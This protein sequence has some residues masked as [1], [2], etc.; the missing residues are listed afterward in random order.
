MDTREKTDKYISILRESFHTVFVNTEQSEDFWKKIESF[1]QLDKENYGKLLDCLYLLEDTQLAKSDYYLYGLKGSFGEKYLRLYGLLNACF[2]QK[3]ALI[4]SRE[5]TKLE[6]VNFEAVKI[7]DYRNTYA[8][9]TPN[10]KG[11]KT[12]N[13]TQ[14][15]R[16]FILCRFSLN[17][18]RV[19]GYSSFPKDETIYKDALLID[20]LQEWDSTLITHLESIIE[21]LF[22][23][24]S[25]EQPELDSFKKSFDIVKG[26]GF[27]TNI[28]D[29][30]EKLNI[31]ISFF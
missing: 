18:E 28:T 14:L 9:H 15:K 27:S 17:E 12:K 21:K 22:S 31:T 7:F 26:G 20:L 25:P 5:C 13:K 30:P 6:K 1:F 29:I 2:L 24:I 16:S 8:A 4:V 11:D 3:E 19:K 10:K 23:C